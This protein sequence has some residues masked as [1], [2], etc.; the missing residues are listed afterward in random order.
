MYAHIVDVEVQEGKL[1]EGIEA[2]RSEILPKL[3]ENESYRG[4]HLLVN[5]EDSLAAFLTWWASP[6]LKAVSF[7]RGLTQSVSP[8]LSG[9]P[10][11]RA[12]EVVDLGDDAA[13]NA[14]AE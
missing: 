2:F 4:G 3:R 14:S 11:H 8:V 9:S 13:P 7:Y 6:C 10:A 12:F 1:E 5:R